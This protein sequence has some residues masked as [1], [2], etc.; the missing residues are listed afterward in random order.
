MKIQDMTETN[1]LNLRR[2]I[3]LT[4]KSSLDHEEAAHKIMKQ[5]FKPGQEVGTQHAPK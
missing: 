4:L 2:D 5:T 3:Y 1:L